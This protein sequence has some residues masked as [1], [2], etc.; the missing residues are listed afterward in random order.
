M[1]VGSATF[2]SA[3]G[4]IVKIDSTVEPPLKRRVA[5]QR[6][7]NRSP[8]F[9]RVD[10]SLVLGTGGVHLIRELHEAL[11]ACLDRDAFNH[12]RGL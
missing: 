6:V 7:L 11:S 1:I 5:N 3:E 4:Y 10:D 9:F 2:D 12:R 8:Q